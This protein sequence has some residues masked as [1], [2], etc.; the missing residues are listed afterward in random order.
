MKWKRTIKLVNDWYKNSQNFSSLSTQ[1]III[2]K[3]LRPHLIIDR[4]RVLCQ[5]EKIA[6]GILISIE[7]LR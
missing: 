7:Y 2:A 4:G 1:A 5:T 3:I 6:N